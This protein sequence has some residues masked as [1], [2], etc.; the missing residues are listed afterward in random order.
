MVPILIVDDDKIT[1]K[2]IAGL[3]SQSGYNDID[4]V[5]SAEECLSYLG[6]KQPGLILMDIHLRKEYD[7]IYT[8]GQIKKEF[9]IPVIYITSASEVKTFQIAKLT[10]PF[11]YL[12][13]PIQKQSLFSTIEIALYKHQ[14]D[15]KIK[16]NERFL[17]LLTDNIQG[18]VYRI[19]LDDLTFNYITKGCEELTGY[20]ADDFSGGEISLQKLVHKE[21]FN[22]VKKNIFSHLKNSESYAQTFRIITKQNEIKWVWDKGAAINGNLLIEGIMSDITRLKY[23]EEQLKLE[24]DKLSLV[25]NSAGLGLVIISRDYKVIWV[26][27]VIKKEYGLVTKK[28]C[29]SGFTDG[30]QF[31]KGCGL[32]AIFD[33]TTEWHSH[34]QK[35]VNKKGKKTW[36]EFITTPLRIE[37]GTVREAL[38]VIIPITEKMRMQKSIRENKQIKALAAHIETIRE[39]EKKIIAREIHD[40][41]GQALT[42]LKFDIAWMKRALSGEKLNRENDIENK[43][44]SMSEILGFTMK[45]VRKITSDL[46]PGMIDNLGF[47]ASVEWNTEQFQERTGI[48]CTSQILVKQVKLDNMRLIA[49]YR[50]FQELMTNI[51]RHSK[52]TQIKVIVKETK[53]NYIII[54]IDNG[55]GIPKEKLNSSKSFGIIGMKERTMLIGGEI[56][57]ESKKGTGTSIKV[58]IPKVEN[59]HRQKN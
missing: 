25:T 16:E 59:E 31:C 34:R 4:I 1:T 33:K 22:G 26:N 7:G 23:A 51:A 2:L 3:L 12:I 49:L 56:F 42:A 50:I 37:G 44:T 47:I 57:I 15:K 39:E 40:Q 45:T 36:L 10:E 14:A 48:N 41:L 29:Y 17:S 18:L 9:D 30:N 32:K 58:K 13:K 5:E 55:I 52:A 38:E 53:R 54:V 24:K 27:D 28:P 8:A 43:F 11:G 35:F 46:R 21:D 20:T 6:K 19:N